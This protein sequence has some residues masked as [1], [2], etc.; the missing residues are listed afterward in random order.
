MNEVLSEHRSI[1]GHV[2]VAAIGM[3]DAVKARNPVVKY[4]VFGRARVLL[5][6]LRINVVVH[7]AESSAQVLHFKGQ[8]AGK[9]RGG[10]TGAHESYQI[11]TDHGEYKATIRTARAE[12]ADG[13]SAHLHGD[14]G[15]C[16]PLG[17]G[18]HQPLVDRLAVEN[19]FPAAGAPK[20]AFRKIAGSIRIKGR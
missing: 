1:T 19:T 7:I 16:A 9:F 11:S 3:I 10:S 15:N 13:A 5:R 8:R 2:V 17:I 20:A 18:I 12:R 6:R 14:I 4:A